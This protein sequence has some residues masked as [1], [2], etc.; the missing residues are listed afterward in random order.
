MGANSSVT[1]VWAPSL[2]AL[3]GWPIES[4]ST[5]ARVGSRSFITKYISR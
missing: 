4:H 3:C 1:V 5:L 2:A